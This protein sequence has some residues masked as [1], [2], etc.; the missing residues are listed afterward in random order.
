MKHLANPVIVEAWKIVAVRKAVSGPSFPG[1]AMTIT[2]E[3]AGDRNA[4]PEMLARHMP[5]PGDYWVRQEDGYE[6]INPKQVFE[7]KYRP[8]EVINAGDA[9]DDGGVRRGEVALGQQE[10]P[11]REEAQTSDR[12]RAQRSAKGR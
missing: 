6:Y 8:L 7:R 2:L 12:H 9:R 5:V 1:K 3:G 10:R 4:T 11:D